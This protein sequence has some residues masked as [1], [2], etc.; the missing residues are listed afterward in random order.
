MMESAGELLFEASA[1]EVP[2]ARSAIKELAHHL[3]RLYG[4][5]IRACRDHGGLRDEVQTTFMCG[6]AL[7]PNFGREEVLRD[8]GA[9]AREEKTPGQLL[10][11]KEAR[12]LTGESW[13]ELPSDTHLAWEQEVM[14]RAE[15][16]AA[17]CFK[18]QGS[19]NM[20]FTTYVACD[21]C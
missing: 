2:F 11:E 17:V 18:C 20:G 19:G 16:K 12:Q 1:H 9:E 13:A 7:E 21:A 8:S 4:E 10:Y 3:G 6:M 5:T 14:T 15:A